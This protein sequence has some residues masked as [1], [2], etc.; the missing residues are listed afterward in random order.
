MCMYVCMYGC[1]CYVWMC[2][3][4]M[5]V[6]MCGVGGM[7]GGGICAMRG[8]ECGR[9]GRQLV[10]LVLEGGYVSSDGWEDTGIRERGKKKLG[11]CRLDW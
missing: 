9:R 4:C 6:S 2:Y 10:W 8:Q 3:V 7:K 11:R 5:Y 1:M